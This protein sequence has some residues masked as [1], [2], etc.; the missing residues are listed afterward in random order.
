MTAAEGKKERR[1]R[2]NK[3]AAQRSREKRKAILGDLAER[4]EELA[5]ENVAL[6]QRIRE[7]ERQ[8]TREAD[9]MHMDEESECG[10]ADKSSLSGDVPLLSLMDPL[11]DEFKLVGESS[12]EAG[13]CHPDKSEALVETPSLQSEAILLPRMNFSM[14]A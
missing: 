12:F 10:T 14:M 7:L 5:R 3:E 11:A 6:K 8:Q 1:R 13:V 4:V 2:M 9:A